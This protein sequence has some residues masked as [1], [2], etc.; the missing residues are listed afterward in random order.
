MTLIDNINYFLKDKWFFESDQ[1]IFFKVLDFPSE[2]VVIESNHGQLLL[3]DEKVDI[4]GFVMPM[5]DAQEVIDKKILNDLNCI[6][7]KQL[8]LV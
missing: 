2:V 5:Y 8:L 1:K 7:A 4:N 6:L 3:I